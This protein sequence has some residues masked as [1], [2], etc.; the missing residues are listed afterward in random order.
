MTSFK[1]KLQGHRLVQALPAPPAE[2]RRGFIRGV[3]LGAVALS[4]MGLAGC[5]GGG[6]G[7]GGD[8][9]AAAF[10]HG[11]ASGDPLADRVILWSRV[12]TPEADIAVGWEVASD[13]GFANVVSSGSASANA[14]TDHTVKV[15]VAGLQPAKAYWYRFK[16]G[17]ATSPVGRTRTLPSGNVSQVRLAVFCCANYPAGYFNVY[18][19][20]AARDDLDATVHLG[21]YLYEYGR[22]EGASAN[23]Q[24]LNRLVQPAAET[25]SLADYRARHAQY[26]TDPDLQALHAR[27]PMIAVWDDHEVANDTYRSGAQNHQPATEGDFAARKAA[28]IQAYHEWMPTRPGA[29][30]RLYRSF[31]FGDLMSL[32]LLD[33][34]VIGRDQQL[35]YAN[36]FSAAG[37]D[38]AG[39]N[40]AVANPERQLLGAEQTLWLQ[41]QLGAST[42]TWQLLGQQVLIGR[43]NIPAAIVAEAT[44]P[45]T[46]VT[47]SQ[48]TAIAAKAQTDPASLTP[49][50][51][52]ILAQPFIPYN[53]DAWDGYAAAR[54]TVLATARSLDKNLVVLSGDTHNAWANDLLDANGNAVGV[55]FATA[56]VSSPGFEASLPNENPAALAASLAQLI[57]PLQYCDT[58]RRGYLLL[59]ATTAQCRADWVYV[60]TVSSRTYTATTGK[61]LRVLP[62]SGQRKISAV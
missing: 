53:L 15:D 21:D 2:D 42:A 60:S 3:A 7:S 14:A 52:A 10:D 24:A 37:F 19:D 27:A 29:G 56:S 28:A 33:T 54:E 11:V 25:L 41:Q 62:G 6:G 34:R 46:G 30:E 4:G 50:E 13:A 23:E 22:G 49:A 43:M 16:A 47:V 9:P 18:A 59:T 1:T 44:H 40:A 61:S 55:E 36:Y 5:G 38:A 17:A 12:S 58:A 20:A 57:V 32:H 51:R 26:K 48:Y 8:A 35:A 45:G 31:D 39:F